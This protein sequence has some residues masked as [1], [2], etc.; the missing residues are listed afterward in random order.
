MFL[1]YI[2]D[3]YRSFLNTGFA[4]FSDAENIQIVNGIDLRLFQDNLDRLASFSANRYL[5]IDIEKSEHT[6]TK[7]RDSLRRS[8]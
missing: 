5:R 1:I 8:I 7:N 6:S 3:I 4:F 2:N